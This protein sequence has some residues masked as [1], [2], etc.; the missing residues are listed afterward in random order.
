[1]C[2][3]RRVRTSRPRSDRDAGLSLV[4]V[5]VAM[6]VF[7]VGSLSLLTVL[8]S[9]S[10]S[11]YDNRARLTATNLA[12]SDIDEARS[13]PYETLSSLTRTEVVDG[14]TYTVVR[15]VAV[16]MASGGSACLTNGSPRQREKR[17]STRVE[18]DWRGRAAPVRADTVVSA[19]VFDA[20]SLRGA[21]GFQVLDRDG[22]PRQGFLVTVNGVS[23]STD[24]S[25]CAFFGDL[26][27]GPYDVTVAWPGAV[28]LA[29]STDLRRRVVVLQGQIITESL[30]IDRAA[31]VTV[32]S[33]VFGTATPASFQMPTGLAVRLAS[34]MREAPTRVTPPQTVTGAPL[35]FPVFP[36]PG[37]YE[38]YF[39]P[40]TRAVPVASEPA[41]NVT[42]E[43]PLSPVT[44]VMKTQ[45]DSMQ[46]SAHDRGIEVQWRSP[47]GCTET[48]SYTARTSPSCAGPSN[49]DSSSSCKVLIAVPAGTWRFKALGVVFYQEATIASKTAAQVLIEW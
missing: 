39:S 30:R 24:A 9:S 38:A 32:D 49:P 17:V 26:V 36:D 42:V 10:S 28:T 7:V 3:S 6:G 2:R 4:E 5:M 34:P 12:A 40:C 46:P 15:E 47:T 31:N 21:L 29:G 35:Q 48:L 23:V 1:M 20:A 45:N 8:S 43:L 11:T 19:P 33:R 22:R 16:T 44:V 14:R 41:S 25:G 13:T 37:G 18:T 27:P